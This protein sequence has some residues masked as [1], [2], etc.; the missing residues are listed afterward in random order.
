MIP[1]LQPTPTNRASSSSPD[2]TSVVPQFTEAVLSP[3]AR[4]L[5]QGKVTSVSL[6]PLNRRP[7]EGTA[8]HLGRVPD[9]VRP[10]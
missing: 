7:T 5:R 6:E 1:Q 8:T 10:M 4:A 9:L 3:L 2:S